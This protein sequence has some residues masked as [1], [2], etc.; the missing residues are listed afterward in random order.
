MTNK[1]YLLTYLL[2]YLIFFITAMNYQRFTKSS[3]LLITVNTVIVQ[4]I[5]VFCIS[6][7]LNDQLDKRVSNI[8]AVYY[9][10]TFLKPCKS[11]CPNTYFDIN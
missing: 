9:G 1:G 3:L 2:T 5:Q 6:I 4:G 7:S 8:L 10:T 11:R